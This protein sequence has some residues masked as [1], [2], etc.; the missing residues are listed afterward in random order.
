MTDEDMMGLTPLIYNHVIDE[1][2]RYLPPP[3]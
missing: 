2:L 3:G 1:H